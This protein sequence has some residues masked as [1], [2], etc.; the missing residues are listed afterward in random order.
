MVIAWDLDLT[1]V[2]VEAEVVVVE[3][4]EKDR[5]GGITNEDQAMIVRH[6]HPA[7]GDGIEIDRDLLIPVTEILAGIGHQMADGVIEVEEGEGTPTKDLETYPRTEVTI[8]DVQEMEVGE[9]KDRQSRLDQV[10]VRNLPRAT[11]RPSLP[12]AHHHPVPLSA[13]LAL[14][15][16][17]MRDQHSIIST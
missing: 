12:S 10:L 17:V 4:V 1:E 3:V 2:E 15:E 13:G 11:L 9:G 5:E 14:V 7:V 6:S 16:E 8:L